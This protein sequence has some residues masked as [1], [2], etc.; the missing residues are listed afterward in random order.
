MGSLGCAIVMSEVAP[1]VLF[2]VHYKK[3]FVFM[4]GPWLTVRAC[5]PSPLLQKPE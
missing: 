1:E 5:F 4:D 3:T 2:V